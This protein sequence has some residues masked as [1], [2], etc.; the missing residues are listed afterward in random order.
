MNTSGKTKIHYIDVLPSASKL[1]DQTL[2]I[3][4]QR[5]FQNI[6]SVRK[7]AK[8]V[9]AVYPVRAGEGLKE[10]YAFPVHV[11]KILDLTADLGRS[12]LTIIALGGGSV[13]DFAGFVASV[14]RRGVRLVHIPSTWLAA[15]DS[16]HGG[17][18]GLNVK[19]LKNAIGTFYVADETYIVGSLLKNQSEA[20]AQEA[21]GE[22]AK[23]AVLSGGPWTQGLRKSSESLDKKVWK[24]LRPSIVAKYKVTDQDPLEIKGIRSILNLGH[25]FG[26]VIE[27]TRGVPHGLAV[28]QGLYFSMKWSLQRDLLSIDDYLKIADFLSG[29][30]GLRCWVDGNAPHNWRPIRVREAHKFLVQDKK[31]LTKEK[32]QFVFIEGW[33]KPKGM[34]VTV[35]EILKEARRQGWVSG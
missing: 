35:Q 31:R 28:A 21:A 20:R 16:A 26:H 17:K 6:S 30:L 1:G 15:M 25:T 8:D 18:N 29:S 32:L 19:G 10:V 33:G 11:R 9:D 24:Y 27:A 23:M 3:V 34:G 12:R 5:V 22:L 14:L 7:L 2:L 13:G 4:D